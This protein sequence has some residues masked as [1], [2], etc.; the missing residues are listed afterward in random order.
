MGT[1]AKLVMTLWP[2]L[3]EMFSKDKESRLFVEQNKHS[4][5]ATAAATFLFLL[6]VNSYLKNINF[7]QEIMEARRD[8]AH[9][10][11]RFEAAN[12][13]W[14]DARAD[15]LSLRRALFRCAGVPEYMINEP[16]I[17]D[18]LRDIPPTP[19]PPLKQDLVL[20]PNRELDEA[21][22][23]EDSSQ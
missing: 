11:E 13:R 5:Y 9:Y 22:K 17:V 16:S 21:N 1:F 14:L 18:E 4:L 6:F 23:K 20:P 19:A 8:A 2:F 12:Q 7:S 15:N 3:R 10:K